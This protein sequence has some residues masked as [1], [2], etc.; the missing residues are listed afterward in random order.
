MQPPR[1]P[2]RRAAIGVPLALLG[3]ALAFYVGVI[4]NHLPS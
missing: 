4:I 3:I 1:A 2:S